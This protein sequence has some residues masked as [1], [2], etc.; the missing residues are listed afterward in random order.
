MGGGWGIALEA[1]Q[2]RGKGRLRLWAELGSGHTNQRQVQPVRLLDNRAVL[3]PQPRL[4]ELTEAPFEKG[5]ARLVCIRDR[6]HC[7]WHL[8]LGGGV[9]S[10]K[11][12]V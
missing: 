9:R 11:G 2:G 7:E 12:V 4:L 5:T 10:G 6:S 1:G 3:Q 8:L